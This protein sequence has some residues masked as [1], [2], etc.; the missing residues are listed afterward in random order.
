L[1]S[2]KYKRKYLEKCYREK[3][4]AVKRWG[5]KVGTKYI[6]HLNLVYAVERIDD[7]YS[8]PQLGFHPLKGNRKG[9]HSIIL[10]RRARLIVKCEGDTIIIIEE[11]SVGHYE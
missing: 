3:A 7:L 1:I 9:Q 11:V 5:P 4:E 8:L 6:R 2:V 10:T